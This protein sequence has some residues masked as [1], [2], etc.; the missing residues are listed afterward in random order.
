MLCT[1]T[2]GLYLAGSDSLQVEV[3]VAC[4]GVDAVLCDVL[5]GVV[6]RSL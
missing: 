2:S 1:C 6:W 4:G 3:G 5:V